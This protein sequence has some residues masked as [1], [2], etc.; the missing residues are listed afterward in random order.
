MKKQH[1]LLLVLFPLFLSAQTTGIIQKNYPVSNGYDVGRAVFPGASGYTLFGYGFQNNSTSLQDL[2]MLQVDPLGNQLSL[3][4]YGTATTSESMGRGVL[5]MPDGGWLLAAG[6]ANQGY[7][8]R[9]NSAGTELW[10]KK[11]PGVAYFSD[12]A[13]LPEGGYIVVGPSPALGALVAMRLSDNGE[14]VWKNNYP[15]SSPKRM[16]ITQG[17]GAFLVLAGNSVSKIRTSNG[18]MIWN[19]VID[20]PNY[21][22]GEGYSFFAVNDLVPTANGQFVL[23]G[24]V[25]SDQITTLYSAYYAALWDESGQVHWTNFYND[26]DTGFDYS[27]GFSCTYLPNSKNILFAGAESGNSKVYRL[28][29]Q[30]IVLDS[31]DLGITGYNVTPVM[32][33][34]GGYYVATGG[35]LA[36]QGMN[37]FFY[38]SAGNIF[39]DEDAASIATLQDKV[40]LYPNPARQTVVA[41]LQVS[42]EQ[43]VRAQWIDAL[44]RVVQENSMLLTPGLN[45]VKMNIAPLAPGAYWLAFPGLPIAP[46]KVL[47]SN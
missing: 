8:L 26:K 31:L 6:S 3:K 37:T 33:K 38:R 44:G 40:L 11:I 17:G 2:F 34:F 9:L 36:A 47:I 30:G 15:A 18:L 35:T 32:H 45:Q 23:A 21:K 10:S 43:M 28:N 42:T 29:L 25:Y 20:D 41:E 14:I 1:F 12:I 7:L 5:Q 22:F 16:Y 27:E 46:A 4:H 13:P 24:N 39:R 19:K